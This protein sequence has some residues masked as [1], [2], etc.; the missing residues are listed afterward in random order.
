MET[1]LDVTV[2]SERFFKTLLKDRVSVMEESRD[3]MT[4]VIRE[5]LSGNLLEELNFSTIVFKS[6]KEALKKHM[7]YH[8]FAVDIEALSRTLVGTLA[9][10]VFIPPNHPFTKMNDEEKET[11]INTHLGMLMQPIKNQIR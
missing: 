11:L 1:E 10:Y 6:L 7:E 2:P 5:S 3:L 9:S 4:L 8:N